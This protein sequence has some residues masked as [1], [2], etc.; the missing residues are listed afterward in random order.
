MKKCPVV[1]QTAMSE[2]EL[3]MASRGQEM[4]TH[5]QDV[6]WPAKP[7]GNLTGAMRVKQPTYDVCCCE[8]KRCRGL[9]GLYCH[10]P[11]GEEDL[12]T[13]GLQLPGQLD[14]HLREWILLKSEKNGGLVHKKQRA[15]DS[16]CVKANHNA[17][18]SASC[19]SKRTKKGDRETSYPRKSLPPFHWC[20]RTI[21]SIS[22][23]IN[24]I[25]PW[26]DL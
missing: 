25:V 12:V 4:D 13:L 14:A 6:G 22:N 15:S 26:E 2:Y 20:R 17:S 19:T 21:L 18:I 11:V 5:N 9:W 1:Y 3:G 23:S 24:L 8:P 10:C 16:H 7:E